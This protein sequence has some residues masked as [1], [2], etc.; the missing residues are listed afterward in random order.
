MRNIN[1]P[2]QLGIPVPMAYEKLCKEISENWEEIREL[3][4]E[5]TSKQDYK[6]SRIHIRKLKGSESLFE[7]NY[8]NWRLDGTPD[9]DLI[10]GKRFLVKADIYTCFP[11]IYTHS[12]PWAFVGKEK[13]KETKRNKNLHY[14]ILD[15]LCQK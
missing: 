12:I 3:L 1:I 9:D 7:M 10:L 13:A 5:N 4:K 11:S 2:R 15:H 14:N 6:V 8:D